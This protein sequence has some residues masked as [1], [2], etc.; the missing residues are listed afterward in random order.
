MYRCFFT[1]NLSSIIIKDEVKQVQSVFM[2]NQ[3]QK[4]SIYDHK[5]HQAEK[6]SDTLCLSID[7]LRS[8]W[9]PSTASHWLISPFHSTNTKRTNI[10]AP[11][12]SAGPECSLSLFLKSSLKCIKKNYANKRFLE[13]PN[14]GNRRRRIGNVFCFTERK[15]EQ[16]IEGEAEFAARMKKI[17]YTHV[18]PVPFMSATGM[19]SGF[20]VYCIYS[21]QSN[22]FDP[23]YSTFT[24][25]LSQ[26]VSPG[27]RNLCPVNNSCAAQRAEGATAAQ[28][29]PDRAE[30]GS[31]PRRENNVMLKENL[32]ISL[33]KR[34]FM[35]DEA[36]RVWPGDVMQLVNIRDDLPLVN[37]DSCGE[38]SRLVL[39]QQSLPAHSLFN[40][41]RRFCILH[42]ATHTLESFSHKKRTATPTSTMSPPSTRHSALNGLKVSV[43]PSVA[44]TL[45]VRAF[46]PT[47]APW[48]PLYTWWLLD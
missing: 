21:Q 27:S 4:S 37:P 34:V 31:D 19:N 10:T 33:S 1:F 16:T 5:K 39:Q 24:L 3:G 30:C 35:C 15:Y 29:L 47:T 13:I 6:L 11:G 12:V 25:S 48:L 43:H 46:L 7:L 44:Q 22:A 42:T 14:D 41:Q 9:V 36:V 40:P 17:I 45:N 20:R 23:C 2:I 32:L 18:T 26:T 8:V 38:T 28:R